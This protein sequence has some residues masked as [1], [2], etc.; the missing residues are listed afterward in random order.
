MKIKM[1]DLKVIRPSR[2]TNLN[3]RT[4]EFK[5]LLM[6]IFCPWRVWKLHQEIR[7]LNALNAAKA[8]TIRDLLT[9]V[10]TA[11]EQKN[12]IQKAARTK[13]LKKGS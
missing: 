2:W 8:D 9:D 7:E 13:F 10:E 4:I 12:A 1:E 6:I 5:Q 11:V 3:A